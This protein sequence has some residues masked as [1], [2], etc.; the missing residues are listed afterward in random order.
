VECWI[1]VDLHA[2]HRCAGTR[3]IAMALLTHLQ[4]SAK[5]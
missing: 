1:K 5:L 2:Q 4:K 3:S